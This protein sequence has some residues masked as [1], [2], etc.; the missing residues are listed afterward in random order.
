MDSGCFLKVELIEFPYRSDMAYEEKRKVKQNFKAFGLSNSKSG[1]SITDPGRSVGGGSLSPSV[2]INNISY[3]QMNQQPL[4]WLEE[5]GHNLGFKG[6][7]QALAPMIQNHSLSPAHLYS[8]S[9]SRNVLKASEMV[10]KSP[11]R[12]WRTSITVLS[13]PAP[14]ARV[15]VIPSCCHQV[16]VH[17]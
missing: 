13:S 5:P 7:A 3:H 2:F 11:S 10:T 6:T 16:A 12:C 14:P 8:L 4:H 15:A 17:C 1:V 9:Q